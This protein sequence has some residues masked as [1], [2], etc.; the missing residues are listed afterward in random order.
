MCLQQ[1]RKPLGIYRLSHSTHVQ[2]RGS[3]TRRTPSPRRSS[4]PPAQLITLSSSPRHLDRAPVQ[5]T[6]PEHSRP[7]T[8]PVISTEPP[9]RTRTPPPNQPPAPTRSTPASGEIPW[10]NRK[11]L[12][13]TLRLPTYPAPTS[14]QRSRHSGF[15]LSTRASFL[16]RRHL[17]SCFSRAMAERML[18]VSS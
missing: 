18:G 15:V 9:C 4:L 3:G 2:P 14:S 8:D 1:Q 16:L 17:F 12:A 11:A 13:E 6:R 5:P 10:K 7:S